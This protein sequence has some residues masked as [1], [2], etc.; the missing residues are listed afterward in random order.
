MRQLAVWRSVI[1]AQCTSCGIYAYSTLEAAAQAGRCRAQAADVARVLA[2]LGGTAVL[3]IMVYTFL[4]FV[5]H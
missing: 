5:V 1:N 2:T 4:H 3:V